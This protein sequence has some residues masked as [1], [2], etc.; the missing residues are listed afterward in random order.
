MT[1]KQNKDIAELLGVHEVTVSR[2]RIGD[3]TPSRARMVE[4]EKKLGWSVEEQM[5]AFEQE[6]STWTL[7][8]AA[9]FRAFLEEAFGIPNDND[10]KQEA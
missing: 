6:T 10:Q 8:Y 3:R 4:I 9:A 7:V 2:W 1:P 5:R